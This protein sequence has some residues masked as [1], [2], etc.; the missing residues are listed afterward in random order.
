ME[1]RN[2]PFSRAV[3]FFFTFACVGISVW[4]LHSYASL[5]SSFF[6]AA[7]VVM[8]ASPI[9]FWLEK[10]GAPRWLA[11][12]IAVLAALGAT[13]I[14]AAV[15][16]IAALRMLQIVPQFIDSFEQAQGG[17]GPILS[18]LGLTVQE[19]Q[20][21]IPP[22]AVAN[23]ITGVLNSVRNSIS[24][25]G[26]VMLIVIFMVIE[27]FLV[28]AKF[29]NQDEFDESSAEIATGFT[30][31]IRQYVSITSLLGLIG[32]AVLTLILYWLGIPFPGT[33]GVLYFI[34]NFVPMVGFWIAVI[35]PMM[36]AGMGGDTTAAL[37]VLGSYMIISTII[38]QVVKPSIMRSGLDLSPFWS[39]MSLIVWSAI[40]GPVGFIV[41]VPLT[42]A[43]KEL[44][45]ET[46]PQ[47]HWI[48]SFMG[49]GFNVVD[50][51]TVAN[52]APAE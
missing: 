15:I 26:L 2:Q 32:G 10:H 40:L 29:K 45:F 7:M 16:G 22:A 49:G 31:N 37:V 36:L 47:S 42:I 21:L 27:A 20:A 30:N 50:E 1:D 25:V 4:F 33:W 18:Y 12:L 24:M 39:I 34:M 41:G 52:E 35:P 17:S 23:M 38:N 9:G 13:F 3:L 43:L 14:F 46:D 6:L 51:I 48:A 44:L 28:P 5:F 19:I 11:L 8:T